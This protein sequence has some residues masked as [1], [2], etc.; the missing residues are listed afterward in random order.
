NYVQRYRSLVAPALGEVRLQEISVGVL[1]GF[2]RALAQRG[3][4]TATRRNVR[5]VLSGALGI[6]TRHGVYRSNPARDMSRIE[7]TN[8]RSVRA[9]T[10]EEVADLLA[11][12][13]ADPKAVERDLPALVRFMIG[14]GVRIGEAL[15][16][17][18]CDVDLD[19]GS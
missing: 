19:A 12:L 18:W 15:A 6:A 14:T 9:L 17:R 5:T 13:D 7:S 10:Q 3:S 16:L 4:S 8:R 1:D 11:K 2:M